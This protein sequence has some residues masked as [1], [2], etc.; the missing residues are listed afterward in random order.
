MAQIEI[1]NLTF[2]YSAITDKVLDNISL[3]IA[4]GEIIVVCGK[5]GCGKTTFLRQLKPV[6]APEGKRE[7]KIIFQGQDIEKIE[8]RYQAREIGFVMQN[9]ENQIVTDRVWQEIAFGMENLGYPREDIR[10]RTAEMME[11]F[12]MTDLYYSNVENL[13][14][15]QKQLLNLAAAMT[16]DPSVMILDEPTAQ[17]D[18][19][20]AENFLDTIVKINKDLGTTIIISEH[21]LNNILPRADKVLLLEEGKVAAFDKPKKVLLKTSEGDYLK[22][23]PIPSQI[24]I[25]TESKS[26]ETKYKREADDIPLNV[27]SGRNWLKRKV[28][29]DTKKKMQRQYGKKNMAGNENSKQEPAVLCRNIWFRYERNG[30]DIVSGLNLKVMPGEIFAILGGNGTGKTTTLSILS[31]VRKAYRGKLQINGSISALPQNVQT[32]F[33]KETVREEIFNVSSEIIEDLELSGILDHHPY[34]ISFGQQ[35]KLALAMVLEKNPDI[36]LLDEPTKAIDNIYKEKLGAFLTKLKEKGKTIILV[37][38][39][40]DFCGEY[41]DRCGLFAQGVLIAENNVKDFFANNRFYTT[42]V[43]KMTSG[44]IEQAVKKEDVICFLTEENT[45]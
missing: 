26:E 32:L 20:A 15:G 21:R 45:I 37:S 19:I 41:A 8:D 14:G 18:P 4:E 11:Y 28:G 24:Y 5:T 12:G 29:Y 16:L 1:K 30:S 31:G 36:L 35:Q 13:S 6:I 40:T 2:R 10:L 3:N 25:E 42:T 7:G 33:R 34:D 44:I 39:D 23:M 43:R 27:V 17:L 38:H 9:P 22:L